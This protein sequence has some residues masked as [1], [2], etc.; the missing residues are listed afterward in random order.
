[1]EKYRDSL[2]TEHISSAESNRDPQVLLETVHDATA[3]SMKEE[4]LFAM[5][6]RKH[7]ALPVIIKMFNQI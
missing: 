1:M 7:E 2:M 4:L 5:N 6:K 3:Y